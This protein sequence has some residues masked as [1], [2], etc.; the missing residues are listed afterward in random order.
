M[1]WALSKA[2]RTI[3]ICMEG[4]AK[5]GADTASVESRRVDLSKCRVDLSFPVFIHGVLFG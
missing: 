3:V 2:S 1:V 5:V 4:G